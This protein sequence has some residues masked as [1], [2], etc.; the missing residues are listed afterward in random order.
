M[1]QQTIS[2]TTK[3]ASAAQLWRLMAAVDQWADWDPTIESARLSGPFATGSRFKLRPKGGPA[4][5]I[6]LE[7]VREGAYFRDCTRFP[8]ARMYGEHWYEP[9]ADGLKITVTMTMRGPLGF[10]WNRLVM[11]DIV[12]NLPEDLKRQISNAR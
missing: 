2:V 5:T 10:L 1:I 8:G 6:R 7:E 11:K 3:E 12:A 4:V 9:V